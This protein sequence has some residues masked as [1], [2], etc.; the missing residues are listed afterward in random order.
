MNEYTEND[1]RANEQNNFLEWLSERHGTGINVIAE[2]LELYFKRTK[3]R[4]HFQEFETIIQKQVRKIH[5]SS[6]K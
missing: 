2:S 4:T 6:K 5:K 1:R 3:N